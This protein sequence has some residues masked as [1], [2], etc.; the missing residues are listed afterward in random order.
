M[1]ALW[2][3]GLLLAGVSAATASEVQWTLTGPSQAQRG[4]PVQWQAS[5]AVSPDSQGLAGYAFSIAIG[6]SPGPTPGPDGMWGTADDENVAAVVLSP[7]TWVKSF[8][9]QGSSSPGSVKDLPAQGGPGMS[10]LPSAGTAGVR[11]GELVQV[12]AGHLVWTPASSVAGVGLDTRKAA[13]LANPAGAYVLHAGE[14]PTESLAAGR[15]TVVLIPVRARVL[16][17]GVDFSKTQSGFIMAQAGGVGSSFEFEVTVPTIP[18][19][20]DHDGDVDAADLQTFIACATGPVIPYAPGLP[21]GCPLVPDEQGKTAADFD[22]DG[23]VDQVDFGIFQRCYSGT[24]AGN[25]GCAN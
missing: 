1:R 5:V 14:I 4:T 24:A 23:D 7:A 2:L 8:R 20:F 17:L 12:G 11:V 16:R 22:R 18:G 25:P 13:L 10:V 15:Y 21:G 6:P 19:D 9:I 3:S